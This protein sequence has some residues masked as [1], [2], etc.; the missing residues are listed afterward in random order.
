MSRRSPT[1]AIFENSIPPRSLGEAALIPASSPIA[2]SGILFYNTLFDENASCHLALGEC[3]P[4]T[5]KGGEELTE[6]EL[7]ARGGNRSANH[8]D[9]MIGTKDLEVVG[10]KHD[11]T[12][13]RI[14]K[15][16]EFTI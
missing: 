16:G 15:D 5:M 8:V 4:D 14:M 11:G 3:Y 9:F 13:V 1:S 12:E 2:T 7:L 10:I 6:E